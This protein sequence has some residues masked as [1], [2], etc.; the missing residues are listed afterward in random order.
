MDAATL[1]PNPFLADFNTIISGSVGSSFGKGTPDH[2]IVQVMDMLDKGI[3]YELAM[4]AYRIAAAVE[5]K[6]HLR[7]ILE[8]DVPTMA[9]VLENGKAE[10]ED[11]WPLVQCK[12]PKMVAHLASHVDAT[13]RAIN[14]HYLT[15][16]INS[17][18]INLARLH[19]HP[20]RAPVL[21]NISRT[22]SKSQRADVD[23]SRLALSFVAQHGFDALVRLKV[24]QPY[25]DRARLVL[26]HHLKINLY[27]RDDDS[28]NDD[29]TESDESEEE[30]DY[31]MMPPPP[32]R[33]CVAGESDEEEEATEPDDPTTP[34]RVPSSSQRIGIIDMTMRFFT[35]VHGDEQ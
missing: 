2:G 8:R 4:A 7:T 3:E 17:F 31:E 13:A 21:P 14:M 25:V 19:V 12:L 28:D 33:Q 15:N 16:T 30:I 34:E 6:A 20:E 26:E 22:L 23:N 5:A 27:Y 29:G 11:C 1:F 24:M 9:G 35:N 32:K 10:A 18:R